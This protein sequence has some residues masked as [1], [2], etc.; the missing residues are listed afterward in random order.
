[1]HPFTTARRAGLCAIPAGMVALTLAFGPPA[2]AAATISA[3]VDAASRYLALRIAD[4]GGRLLYDPAPSQGTQYDN[5]G[6][7]ADAMMG[8]I[9]S[10]TSMT[11]VKQARTYLEKNVANYIGSGSELY[12]GATAKLLLTVTSSASRVDPGPSARNFGGVDLIARLQSLQTAS[13]RF[14]DKSSY[15]DY[16]NGITQSLGVLSLS[17]LRYKVPTSVSYLLKQQ[18][19]NGGF[20]LTLDNPKGCTSD[21]D[22]T[23]YAVQAL[24][25]AGGQSGAVAKAVAYLGAAQKP[26]GAI[27]T[28]QT[29]VANST[30]LA[31]MAFTAAG[32]KAR[33]EKARRYLFTLQYPCSTPAKLRGAIAANPQILAT[34]IAQGSKATPDQSD[35]VATGQALVAMSGTTY[36]SVDAELTVDA[37]PTDQCASTGSATSSSTSSSSTSTSTSSAPVTGPPVITDGAETDGGPGAVGMGLIVLGGAALSAGGVAAARHSRGRHA[38]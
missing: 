18:C 4:G 8:M 2:T 32:D 33:W 20:D 28:G 27:G 30:A 31:A 21:P 35:D 16:S 29:G 23:G 22:T 38:R 26:S 10:G 25:A 36:V 6:G 15:G 3:P 14:S 11:A 24:V 5:P 37:V 9:A 12:S 13:G 17:R 19:S 1:M 7:T 34:K